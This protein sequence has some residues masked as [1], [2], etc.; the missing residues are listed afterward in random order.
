M[1]L[2]KRLLR[3]VFFIGILKLIAEVTTIALLLLS[4]YCNNENLLQTHISHR[5]FFILSIILSMLTLGLMVAID[6]REQWSV[7]D[8]VHFSFKE[9]MRNYNEQWKRILNPSRILC[10]VLTGKGFAALADTFLLQILFCG[11]ATWALIACEFRSWKAYVETCFLQ[12]EI[13]LSIVSMF[14]NLRFTLL[15]NDIRLSMESN[16]EKEINDKL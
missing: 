9:T 8:S 2:T 1:K 15:C 6:Y 16:Q 3:A 13:L 7:D 11:F 12:P 5:F 14:L 4:S 10:S